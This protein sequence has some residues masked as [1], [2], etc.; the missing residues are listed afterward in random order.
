MG[1]CLRYFGTA[2]AKRKLEVKTKRRVE[3]KRTRR[4]R[5]KV[6][7]RTFRALIPFKT[8]YALGVI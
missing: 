6:Y 2:S 7:F 3:E 8:G 4:E 5:M 1:D